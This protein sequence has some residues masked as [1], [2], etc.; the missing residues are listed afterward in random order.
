MWGN[1]P[2]NQDPLLEA[3]YAR[4]R[5]LRDMAGA[6]L[7]GA[8]AFVLVLGIATVVVSIVK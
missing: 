1:P 7:L 2:P 4:P 6:F 5:T 8:L 3:K